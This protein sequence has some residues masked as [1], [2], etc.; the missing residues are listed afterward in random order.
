[1]A[2]IPGD[3]GQTAKRLCL[4]NVRRRNLSRFIFNNVLISEVSLMATFKLM[5]YQSWD[6]IILRI[7]RKFSNFFSGFMAAILKHIV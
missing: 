7:S 5:K 3:L 6:A 4:V 1:M 2:P